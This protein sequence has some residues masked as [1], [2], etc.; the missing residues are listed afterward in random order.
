MWQILTQEDFQFERGISPEKYEMLGRICDKNRIAVGSC[1]PH[2]VVKAIRNYH[3]RHD[4]PAPDLVWGDVTMI[5]WFPDGDNPYEED[6]EAESSDWEIDRCDYLCSR[7]DTYT[8]CYMEGHETPAGCYCLKHSGAAED[9]FVKWQHEVNRTYTEK[10]N[11][12]ICVNMDVK[13][14]TLR[15]VYGLRVSIGV[16]ERRTML[17]FLRCGIV[18]HRSVIFTGVYY[19]VICRFSICTNLWKSLDGHRL[20]GSG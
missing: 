2:D 7:C 11:P 18:N 1:E 16:V 12:F 5:K 6:S 17:N 15:M 14:H 4:I 10:E 3:E 13:G 19:I 9:R 20:K 8:C